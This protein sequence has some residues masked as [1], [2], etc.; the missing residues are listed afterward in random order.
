MLADAETGEGVGA[1]EP[2]GEELEGE[3]RGEGVGVVG[4]V[5]LDQVV[6]Q[7]RLGLGGFCVQLGFR[8]RDVL[9]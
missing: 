2:L 8:V 5:R 6:D 3:G 1:E 9:Y 4:V 7:G